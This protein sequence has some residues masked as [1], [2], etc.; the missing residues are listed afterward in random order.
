M[1]TP[2]PW[3]LNGDPAREIAAQ[4]VELDLLVLGSRGYGPL[5]R[6]LLGGVARDVVT[7]A[8]C[9]V[10]VLPRSSAEV[11]EAREARD[12]DPALA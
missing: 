2:R 8:P 9:P 5:R 10:I 7:L 3:S 1:S 12:G 6:T 4:G 11:S